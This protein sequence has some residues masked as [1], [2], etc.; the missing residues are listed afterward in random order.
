MMVDGKTFWNRVDF[1][2]GEIDK[3][4]MDLS[5]SAKIVYGT[6]TDSRQR[7]AL[8]KA[9]IIFKI[10]KFLNVPIDRLLSDAEPSAM[11]KRIDRIRRACLVASEEDLL[12]VERILRIDSKSA[13]DN[14][15]KPYTLRT[16]K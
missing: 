10:S 14:L 9:E 3:T 4:L 2:L 6:M 1:E 5:K 13:F 15:A 8:P 16:G 12:L 7:E 11:M